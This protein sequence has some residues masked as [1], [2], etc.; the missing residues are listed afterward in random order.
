MSDQGSS[1]PAPEVGGESASHPDRRRRLIVWGS[2]AA[3]LAAAVAV[4]LILTSGGGGTPTSNNAQNVNALG[5]QVAQL[6]ALLE[7]GQKAK[8]H[9][10]YRAVIP[11][12]QGQQNA[13]MSIQLWRSPP[14]LRQDVVISSGGQT[15][16]SSSFLLPDGAIGCTRESAT[17]AWNCAPVPKEQ[18]AAPDTLAEQITQEVGGGTVTVKSRQV[19]GIAV[20][21]FD[22]PVSEAAAEVCVTAEGIPALI[23]SAGTRIELV[24]LTEDVPG[25]VFT[26]PVKAV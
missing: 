13:S 21:C 15:A 7:Q 25:D 18:T 17:A 6:V 19:A 20:T 2:I 14:R 8:Y 16:T 4:I 12:Q 24:H 3:V 9:A 10:E 26:P 5:P 1:A 11:A 22:L 23:S